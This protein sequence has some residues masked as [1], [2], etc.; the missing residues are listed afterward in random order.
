MVFTAATVRVKNLFIRPQT[1]FC[2]PA[3]RRLRE[4]ACFE[5]ACRTLDGMREGEMHDVKE[6]GYFRT[7]TG[8]DWSQPHRE[9]L[10]GEHAG[11][12]SNC[13]QVFR[14]TGRDEYGRMA[15]EIIDYLNNKLFD[16]A[17]R[18]LLRL[19]GFFAS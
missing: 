7:T 8:A 12:L 9:K 18:R 19:R 16:C 2:L 17:A 10:L 5:H 15:E 13:L 4:V 14:L 6:G 11:L 1:I 3:T